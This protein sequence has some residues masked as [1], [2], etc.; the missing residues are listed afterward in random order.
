MSDEQALLAAIISA[1]DDDTPRLVYADFLDE[2]SGPGD[3]HFAAYIRC[4]VALARGD[5]ETNQAQRAVIA[6]KGWTWRDNP[7]SFLRNL[8]P[9]NRRLRRGFVEC[10]K[11][12][13][14]HWLAIESELFWHPGQ[15][16]PCPPTA[17]PIR[18]L[19][20]IPFAGDDEARDGMYALWAVRN[21]GSLP[22]AGLPLSTV[23]ADLWPGLSI[24]W[25]GQVVR[26][27]SLAR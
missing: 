22:P 25:P 14:G 24:D 12:S 3:A 21:R 8:I 4:N 1:P 5:A 26:G 20:L 16:R 13:A 15:D 11:C 23:V 10:V 18:E 9:G 27:F 17:Q 7:H 19:D 6:E 2:R